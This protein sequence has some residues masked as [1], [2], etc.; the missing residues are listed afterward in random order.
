MANITMSRRAF[1][2]IIT[3][4]LALILTLAVFAADFGSRAAKAERAVE[5]GYM[6]AMSQYCELHKEEKE[7]W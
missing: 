6:L 5:Y 1:A 2:R 4:P 7:Y 3:F